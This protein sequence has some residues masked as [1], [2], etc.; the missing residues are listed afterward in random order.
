MGAQTAPRFKGVEVIVGQQRFAG[1]EHGCKPEQ[2]QQDERRQRQ[3]VGPVSSKSMHSRRWRVVF[4]PFTL[5]TFHPFMM[6]ESLC[7]RG[8]VCTVVSSSAAGRTRF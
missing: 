5:S 4:T 7:C 1:K 6:V 2:G 3:Q 8:G